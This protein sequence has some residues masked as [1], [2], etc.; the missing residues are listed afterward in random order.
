MTALDESMKK[1]ENSLW[2][3]AIEHARVDVERTNDCRE[4]SVFAEVGQLISQRVIEANHSTLAR[5]VI[6]QA[7]HA[8]Q[9]G[10]T[11]DRHDVAVV[12]SQHRRQERLHSLNG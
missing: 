9:T 7:S 12:P 8:E 11:R 10:G 4:D 2:L 3:D 6:S 5:A 1:G